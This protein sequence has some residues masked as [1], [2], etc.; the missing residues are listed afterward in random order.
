MT[1]LWGGEKYN[2]TDKEIEG[3]ESRSGRHLPWIR[4]DDGKK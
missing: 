2:E 4:S 3:D 1:D